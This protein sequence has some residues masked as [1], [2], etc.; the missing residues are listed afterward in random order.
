MVHPINNS[1][2]ASPDNWCTGTLL[3]SII[4]AQW[5][6]MEDGGQEVR[7]GTTSPIPDRKGFK[8]Q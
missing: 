5:E 8:L 1:Y 7:A 3:N 2:S 4:T 6:G